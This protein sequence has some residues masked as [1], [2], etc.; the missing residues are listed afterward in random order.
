MVADL[1][2]FRVFAPKG[3]KR[4]HQNMSFCHYFAFW[5]TKTRNMLILNNDILTGEGMKISLLKISCRRV[6]IFSGVA[7]CLSCLRV[8]ASK[9]EGRSNDKKTCFRVF[10]FLGEDTKTRNG[11]NQPP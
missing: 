9:R 6:E 5:G 2:H 3:E 11:I 10:A 7:L 4:K 8:F 1:C